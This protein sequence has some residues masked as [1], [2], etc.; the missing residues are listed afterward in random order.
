M[1]TQ[2]GCSLRTMSTHEKNRSAIIAG[3]FLLTVP[4][5]FGCA[6]TN[7]AAPPAAESPAPA[8]S[9][10]S[11]SASA[12]A[13]AAAADP[14]AKLRTVLAMAHRSE[15]NRARDQYRHPVETLSFFGI[16]ED[17]TVVEISPGGGW[18]TEIL[19]PMLKDKGQFIVTNSPTGKK[20][21][22]LLTGAPEI[23]GK[24]QI[25][26]FDAG[27][28]MTTLAADGT[29][30]LVLTFRNIHGWM[31]NGTDGKIFAAAYKALKSGGVFG[32]VEHRGKP[33]SDP[34]ELKDTGYVPETYV[35]KKV[36][37]A[38]FKLAAKS[39]INANPK[40][41]KDYPKGVWTLPPTL[42]LGE[43]DKDKYLAI[44]ESD[45]MTL[46]FVKP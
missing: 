27:K 4:Q 21:A 31:P 15:K 6:S 44:G 46:K 37:E 23:Y 29:V 28:D 26:P 35:V 3:V 34:A 1:Y 43:V 9:S 30:D 45:R 17:A 41:T 40:D 38:G 33:A 11:A 7:G 20:F 18:Y 39:E 32:V 22:D 42:R 5:A 10:A 36:E 24:V 2:V 8:V 14:A 19:G 13:P 12:S 25:A 16:R